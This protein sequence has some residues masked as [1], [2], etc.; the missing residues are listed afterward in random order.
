VVT[1]YCTWCGNRARRETRDETVRCGRCVE[2]AIRL[3]NYW[4]W[5]VMIPLAPGERQPPPRASKRR[6]VFRDV[7]TNEVAVRTEVVRPPRLRPVPL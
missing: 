6:F 2:E 3:F 4:P 7:H 1:Y 5:T